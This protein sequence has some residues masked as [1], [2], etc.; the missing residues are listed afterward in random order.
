M[1]DWQPIETAPRDGSWFVTANF[2]V[3]YPEFE[4]GCYSPFSFREYVERE[5][6]LFQA[7]DKTVMEWANF[8]NFNRATHWMPLPAPPEQAANETSTKAPI[9]GETGADF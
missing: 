8:N 2:N 3:D 9:G 1:A 7:V 4:T 5:D 6:G